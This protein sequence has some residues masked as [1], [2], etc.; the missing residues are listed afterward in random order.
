VAKK[1]GV[2][3][4]TVS[5]VINDTKHVSDT[6]KKKVLDAI[7]ET[8]YRPNLTARSLVKKKSNILGVLIPRI[9]NDYFSQLLE[10]IEKEAQKMGYNIILGTSYNQ[11]KK[12]IEYL[13]LFA[14][15]KM[16][17]IIFSVTSYS[18]K[19]QHFFEKANMPT[20]FLGQD[21]SEISNYPSLLINNELAA[22]DATNSL[23][24][25]GH[26]KI[27]LL[28]GPKIDI[29]T[30]IDRKQGFLKAIHESSLNYEDNWIQFAHH[31]IDNGYNNTQKIF[32]DADKPTAL[33]A[34]SDLQAI[35]AMKYLKNINIK[36]PDQVSIMGF[37]NS[38]LS[39][40]YSPSL[41]SVHQNPEVIGEKAV[42]L[43]CKQIENKKIEKNKFTFPHKIIERETFK[44]V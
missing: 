15:R 40:I 30:G 28:S 42:E 31:T 36:V 38:Y 9:A 21:L 35:G 14:E 24:K 33:F 37:D 16:D 19:H 32:S 6:L 44:K 26:K 1:A 12:E 4:S 34:T 25:L 29:A 8:G 20:V 43:I 13:N 41:S 3:P 23:I 11:M 27:G 17:G 18:E 5:R 39:K 22:Y 7:E 2:S 10:G